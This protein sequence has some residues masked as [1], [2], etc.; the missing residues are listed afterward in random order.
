MRALYNKK[1]LRLTVFFVIIFSIYKI[2]AF[3]YTPRDIDF[4]GVFK[5]IKINDN[6]LLYQTNASSPTVGDFL[7]EKGIN[8]DSHDYIVPE[9]VTALYPGIN[10]EIHRA[11]NIRIE[12]DGKTFESY[13][14]KKTVWEALEE[15]HIS[16]GR[17]D[18][19]TP[20]KMSAPTKNA[21]I[22]V[23]RINVEE[24]IKEEPIDFKI[25]VKNDAKMGWREKKIEV[26]GEKGVRQV[27]YKVTYRNGKEIS[28]TILEKNIIKEPAT[29]VEIQGTYVKLGKKH[30]GQGTWYAWKGGFY[31]ASPWLPI[32]SYAKVTNTANGKSIIVEIN[33]RGPFGKGRIIDLDKPAFQKI[34]SLGAGVISVRVEEV[35]N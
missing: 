3:F 8:L 2:S 12:A 23:I 13:T 14:F 5:A 31:A 6:G 24:I 15:N 16:L 27:K 19:T 20:D 7:K 18:K 29:Q 25:S 28:R 30:T 9:A 32:G 22:V 26:P 1:L 4:D 33:D 10:I 17:L 11:T 35:L 21:E 34:A